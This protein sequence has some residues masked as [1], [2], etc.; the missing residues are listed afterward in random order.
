MAGATRKD[1]EMSK[2]INNPPVVN[3]EERMRH[4]GCVPGTEDIVFTGRRSRV[5]CLRPLCCLSFLREHRIMRQTYQD[6]ILD[7]TYSE[8]EVAWNLARFPVDNTGVP[9]AE[10]IARSV[11]DL[12]RAIQ[13]VHQALTILP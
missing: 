6:P 11:R 12:T 3:N 5:G 10:Y 1:A 9:R 2:L 7:L 13:L 8:V 4:C